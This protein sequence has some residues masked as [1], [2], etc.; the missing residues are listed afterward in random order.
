MRKVLFSIGGLLIAA[1]VVVSFV[2]AG[3]STKEG[4]KQATEKVCDNPAGS[5]C[6]AACKH[7]GADKEACCNK[8]KCQAA[9]KNGEGK[10]A[11]ACKNEGACSKEE[12]KPCCQKEAKAACKSNPCNAK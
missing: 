9:C 8:E 11:Q 2:N 3:S 4:K 5:S 10:C 6:A 7:V 12:G 1:F